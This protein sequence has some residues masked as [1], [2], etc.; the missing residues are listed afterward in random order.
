MQQHPVLHQV[1]QQRLMQQMQQI[2]QQQQPQGAGG[3][4][5]QGWSG[6]P[7]SQYGQSFGADPY[8]AW[9]QQQAMASQYRGMQQYQPGQS[10]DQTLH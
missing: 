10:G 7:A 3:I 9:L 6:N 5:P 4:S 2:Q 8:S 1:L